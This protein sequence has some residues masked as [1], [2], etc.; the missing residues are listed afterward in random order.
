[1]RLPTCFSEQ[2]GAIML[3]NSGGLNYLKKHFYMRMCNGALT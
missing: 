1:M 2:V 3:A